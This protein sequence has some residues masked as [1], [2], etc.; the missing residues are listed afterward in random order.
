QGKEAASQGT[1]LTSLENSLNGL[2]VGGANLIR[3]SDTLDGW[4]SRSPSETYQGA[5]VAWTRLVKGTGGY[6]QLDEQ[7]LD[8][9]GKTEFIYSFY[10]KGA[11]AAQE[12]TAYFYN[13]SNT[14]R[15]ET[16]QGYKS[17]AG[18]GAA[19]F[20]LTTSWQRY[21]V[22]WVIPA[23][24]GTKRLIPARLQHAPSADK[25]VWLCRPKLETGNVVT[26]WTPNNDDIAAE[27]QANAGA[28][29]NLSTRVTTAEGKITSSGTAITRLQ[30]DLALTQADVSKKAD[31]T[32][33]Q[34]VQNSVTQ[35]DKDITAANSAITKLTSDLST[36]NANVSKKADASAL[37][38]LQNTITQQ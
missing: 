27:I 35:Q 29:Q 28:V 30:N 31:T 21:W 4:S 8:V 38:T 3:H 16:N 25:E 10:A 12:M 19:Q 26:D 18:D 23:T 11:Y 24:A 34:T 32:A 1:A 13:P 15:I 36:T 22:R 9:T 6:V 37:Q 33:L 5:S 20:T 14:S 17:S 2:S 7:T